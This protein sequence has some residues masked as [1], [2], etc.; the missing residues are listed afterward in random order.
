MNRHLHITLV[1]GQTVPVYQG[2]IYDQPDYVIYI[3]SEQTNSSIELIASATSIPYEL[4]SLSPVDIKDVEEYLD[5]LKS[6][7]QNYE[8]ITINISSGTKI[9]S[10]LFYDYFKN[11]EKAKIIY[12]DQNNKIWNFKTKQCS[13]HEFITDIQNYLI[14]LGSKVNNFKKIENF[15]ASDIQ[16]VKTIEEIRKFD[17]VEFNALTQ[18]LSNHS[19]LN[20]YSTTQGSLIKYDT[21]EKSFYLKLIKKSGTSKECKLK[22]PNIRYLLLNTGWFEFKVANILSKWNHAKQIILNCDFQTKEGALKNEVDV[23]VN[24]GK[25]LLFVECKTQVYNSTDIDKFASVIRNYGGLGTKGILITEVDINK[26]VL[27][28][29]EDNGLLTF[30]LNQGNYMFSPEQMLY[31]KLESEWLNINPR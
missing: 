11:I 4:K 25:K 3:C 28:K 8:R 30:C 24:T 31:L 5:F 2:I 9:W 6:I 1:G 13:D 7:I 21:E 10:I 19:N 16:A 14:I 17:Y 15:D 29:C 20:E 12:I 27:E 26:N 23:I 18:S 22:S